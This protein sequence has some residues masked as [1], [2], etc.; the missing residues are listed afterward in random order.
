MF[1]TTVKFQENS[2][3]IFQDIRKNTN[4]R[5]CSYYFVYHLLNNNCN[6]TVQK[7]HVSG[8]VGTEKDLVQL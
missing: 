5:K 3:S 2:S 4:N 7:L 6:I 1:F 8:G